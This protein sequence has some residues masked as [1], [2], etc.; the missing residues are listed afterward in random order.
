MGI[1]T[2]CGRGRC[3][4]CD[5][6]RPPTPNSDS[7]SFTSF[8][9]CS[10]DKKLTGREDTNPS[11][12]SPRP[13]GPHTHSCS[14][15][16]LNDSPIVVFATVEEAAG[17]L[18]APDDFVRRMSPFD[19]AARMKT[20][21]D[22]SEEEYLKFVG[23]SALAWND[24]ERQKIATAYQEIEAELK[25]LSVP[26]PAKLFFI[27]TTGEEEGGAAYTRPTPSSSHE[28]S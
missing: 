15:N 14:T 28:G 2:S 9:S 20:D 7:C 12:S 26:L 17:I 8:L 21:R 5:N 25:A 27:K 3:N 6:T 19:R 16:T 1:P 10:S 22:V 18:T 13:D 23:A 24:A 4:E 11:D